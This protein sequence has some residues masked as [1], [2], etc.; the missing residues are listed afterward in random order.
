M[1]YPLGN[2]MAET[3]NN[4]T[5]NSSIAEISSAVAAQLI[6]NKT[7]EPAKKGRKKI[8]WESQ[9]AREYIE[10][11]YGTYPHWYRIEVGPLP[12]G[13]DNPIYT[14]VRRYADAIVRM[15]DHMLIIEMKMM[16]KPEVAAQIEIYRDLFRDTPLF[17]KYAEEK[18]VCKV[19]CA[20]CDDATKTYLERRGIELE[21]YKPAN[22]DAWYAKKIAKTE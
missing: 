10:K 16:A 14:K 20:M 11:F 21:I 22:Y 1:G 5:V 8:N 12:E 3:I 15:P 18:V 9:F 19:V 6:A 17:S 13:F 2:Y 7:F 4:L